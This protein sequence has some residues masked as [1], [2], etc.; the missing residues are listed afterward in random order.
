VSVNVEQLPAPLRWLAGRLGVDF[1]PTGRPSALGLLAATL[2]ALGGSLL[3]DYLLVR[4]GIAA[5]PST[6]GFVHFRFSDYAK[7][8]FIGV[9]IACAAWPIV[10]HLTSNPRRLFR[11]SAVAVTI[12]LFAPDLWIWHNG[13]P[14]KAVFVLLWLHVAIAIVTYNALVLLAPARVALR[15][16]HLRC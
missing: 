14:A 11:R 13:S 2:V 6:K 1:R 12:V 16:R 7:L 4:L 15:G 8:T 10:A 3:A 9:L 5:F